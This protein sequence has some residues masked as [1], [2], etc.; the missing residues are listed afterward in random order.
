LFRRVKLPLLDNDKESSPAKLL[1]ATTWLPICFSSLP[2]LYDM[3][4]G[5]N[6][7]QK[8]ADSMA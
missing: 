1:R 5:V 6:D 4:K 2:S 7:S 3:G 8:K